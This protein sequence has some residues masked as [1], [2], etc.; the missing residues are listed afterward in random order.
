MKNIISQVFI[1][2]CLNLITI[3]CLSVPTQA[4]ETLLLSDKQ[5]KYPL[6]EYLEIL[7]DPTGDLSI[8]DVTSTEYETRF[9]ACR[10]KVPNF[11]FTKSA[12]W[13]RFCI[14]NETRVNSQQWRL[15]LGFANMHYIDLYK[16]SLHGQG[17][18][19]IRTG[20]MLPVGTRDVPFHR[21]VFKLSFPIQTEQV[22]FLRFKNDASMTLPL[23]LWSMEAFNKQSQTELFFLG[24]FSGVLIIMFIYNIFVFFSLRDKSYLFFVLSVFIFLMFVLSQRGLAYQYLWPSLIWWNYL[25]VPLFN[26]LLLI[27]FLI[28]TSMFL[29]IKVQFHRLHQ[30]INVLL[31]ISV[32]LI[33]LIPFTSYAIIIQPIVLLSVF[34][35]FIMLMAG[36]RS[37]R[38]GYRPAR[39]FLLSMLIPII[40]GIITSLVRLGLF[41]SNIF[42]EYGIL[43]G[44][45][46]LVALL[47]LG[48]ADRINLLKSETGKKNLELRES[49]KKYRHIFENIQDVYYE[50]ALDG[51]IFEISPS[52]EQFLLYKRDELIGKSISLFHGDAS[53]REAFFK[54]ILE[55]NK[56]YN[57]E[58]TVKNRDGR[59]F[60]CSANS[61]LLRDEQGRPSKIVGSLRNITE[62]KNL[63]G[64]LLQAQKMESIGILAGGIAHDFNNLLTVINGNA[65]LALIDIDENHPL[66][67]RIR[68]ILK[69]GMKAGNLTRQL[70]AF[71]RKGIVDPKILDIN[72]VI[73]DLDKMLHRLIEEDISI[74]TVLSPDILTI[75][76]D[77]AQIE[78]IIINLVVNA[79]D[80][81]IQKNNR[82]STRKITIET[83]HLYLNESYVSHHLGS[84]VGSHI[85]ISVSDS[86]IGIDEEIKHKIFDPFFTTKEIGRGT[87][88]G[89]A[90]V[91]GIVKQNNGSIEVYSEPNHGTTF[92]IYWPSKDKEL[93]PEIKKDVVKKDDFIGHENIL[94]AE[95]DDDVR[96]YAKEVLANFG[97]HVY[98]A[99][100]GIAALKL[101]EV[102]NI[103]VD[104]L[105]TDL[106]MPEM[107]GKELALR[108]K[109]IFPG[110]KTLY[111]SG[112]TNDHIVHQGILEKG[113]HF[114]HKPYSVAALI[115]S[116][117]G[118]L[119]SG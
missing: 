70:L 17:F 11:G 91:F 35:L 1:G 21:F 89:L 30:I 14:R 68:E 6:G 108:V 83:S 67:H 77:P 46:L 8:N 19:V 34:T 32:I 62:R 24:F 16:P 78:Q 2:I 9:I 3:F 12:Y 99:Q 96:D 81:I 41:P 44:I 93:S 22:I 49:E 100:N 61:I 110:I 13:V 38:Q 104:M 42:T 118:V 73:S 116:V 15:A 115:K 114:I 94:L 92:K 109:K 111:V 112:Y 25:S 97:Y 102:E 27:S 28:F 48:L 87:G 107:N 79:R 7:E 23:T 52:I 64:Q 82:E 10:E 101:I 45:I 69:S 39:Y 43:F 80:A 85:L 60:F 119:D 37:W 20:T 5:S 117:R 56:V 65:E 71:S 18:N 75:Q 106:V 76:A 33:I 72:Y 29:N 113:I 98:A 66:S 88:L 95:D 36:F 59:L 90:T 63:E 47:S 53:V 51:T 58:T 84:T 50:V 31:A 26:G 4:Q 86:G 57:F 105:V 55:S 54:K 74:E 103:Q 40:T